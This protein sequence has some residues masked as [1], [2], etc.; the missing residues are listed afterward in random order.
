MRFIHCADLH[1]DSKMDSLPSEKAKIRREEVLSTFERLADYASKINASAVIIAGDMFDTSRTTL[2]TRGRVLEAINK[3]S[4]VDFLYLSG[5]HD[6]D[7][8]LSELE[9]YPS[10]FKVFSEDWQS[11]TYDNTV[12]SG[13]KIN[14]INVSTVYDTLKLDENK[15]NI[16][17]LHGQIA[18]YKGEEHAEKISLP[19]L[20][21]KNIDYLALGHIHEYSSGKLDER[22]VYAYSGCLEGR[23]FDETGDKGFVLIEVEDNKLSTQFIKFSTRNLYEIVFNVEN[24]NSWSEARSELIDYLQVNYNQNSLIKVVLKG[25]RKTD[26]DIDKDGL[27]KRLN[28]IFFF[29]KVYDKTELLVTLEDYATDKSVRGEFVR[30][31]WESDLSAEEKSKIIMC[32]LNALKG[33]EI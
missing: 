4:T 5:N 12:V 7:N 29:A 33:E 32:G 24:K 16:V 9:F 28:D 26:C 15:L 25:G 27:I 23:G 21:N 2:K 18:D 3:N 20:K 1:L 10:N 19:R 13:V 30:S 6:D 17:T 8:F 11:F 14:S 22:G 31:V